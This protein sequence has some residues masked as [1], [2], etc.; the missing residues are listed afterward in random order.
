MHSAAELRTEHFTISVDGTESSDI[1][2]LFQGFREQDRLG[3]VVATP[4]GVTGASRLIL[5][6]VTAYYD[7]QRAKPE[8]PFIYPDYFVFHVGARTGDHNMLDIWPEHKELVTT[9]DPEQ[10]L[11]S[12][13]DRGITRLL[14]ETF[15]DARAQAPG[16]SL[17]L[18]KKWTLNS[19]LARLRSAVLFSATGRV[20]DAD[21]HI[22]GDATAERYTRE[23]LEETMK[24]GIDVNPG[25]VE[26]QVVRADV[27]A[28]ESYRR[29]EVADGLR[30]IQLVTEHL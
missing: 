30:A 21:V 19:A 20:A 14:V 27:G 22:T 16:D 6:A 17:R 2:T 12:I 26:R 10:I 4:G 25:I 24:L 28:A 13:N 18:F 8:H 11:C 1:S 9:G 7:F 23:S 15:G 3:V 5:A 29:V